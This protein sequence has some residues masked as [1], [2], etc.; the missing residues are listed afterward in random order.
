MAV[1][2]ERL[3]RGTVSYDLPSMDVCTDTEIHELESPLRESD[4][5]MGRP[6]RGEMEK[7]PSGN[8]T[9][10][11]VSASENFSVSA[12]RHTESVRVLPGQ[13][14]GMCKLRLG[15]FVEPHSAQAF[16]E[17]LV[18]ELERSSDIKMPPMGWVDKSVSNVLAKTSKRT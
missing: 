10:Q 5:S 2:A 16:E 18:W 6:I 3:Q 9:R 1:D 14:Q 17:G 4:L 13:R 12:E 11:S 15:Y 8:R 7:Y